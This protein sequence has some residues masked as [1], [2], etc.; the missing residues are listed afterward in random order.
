MLAI[1]HQVVNRVREQEMFSC[2]DVPTEEHVWA[3]FLYHSGYRI[4]R[5]ASH[6]KRCVSAD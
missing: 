1:L 6:R 3:A 5:S 2:E 4:E